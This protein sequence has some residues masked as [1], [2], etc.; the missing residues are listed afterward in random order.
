M[1]ISGVKKKIPFFIII[2]IFTFFGSK[3]YADRIGG[4]QVF[5]QPFVGADL[6]N[7]IVNVLRLKDP[8][9]SQNEGSFKFEKTSSVVVAERTV[10]IKGSETDTAPAPTE[11]YNLRRDYSQ[12]P[13]IISFGEKNISE[14]QFTAIKSAFGDKYKLTQDNFFAIN[15]PS[16]THY[17]IKITNPSAKGGY[18]KFLIGSAVKGDILIIPEKGVKELP[19]SHSGDVTDTDMSYETGF[20]NYL[21]KIIGV[22]PGSITA[23]IR[24]NDNSTIQRENIRQEKETVSK[25]LDSVEK[26]LN[27]LREKEAA[28]TLSSEE[29]QRIL[30]LESKKSD[31]LSREENLRRIELQQT[32]NSKSDT[33]SFAECKLF[34]P[35]ACVLPI[36]ATIANIGLKLVAWALGL[37]GVM[38]DYSIELA[39]NSAEFIERLGVVTP[40]WTL[41]RSFEHDLYFYT[42]L[43]SNT[44]NN[45]QKK[46]Y[47]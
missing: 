14:G 8:L 44:N 12:T 23:E 19:I 47:R 11:N 25:E 9:V 33:I 38:F 42:G 37:V 40:V 27:S 36:L 10:L 32:A 24:S 3:V 30:D 39:V 18:D 13:G 43:D 35:Q 41:L 26:E 1:N 34:S 5:R 4:A 7:T 29:R 16:G 15:T 17:Y 6:K 45:R 31:L 2:F 46:I 21:S 22:A 20:H 28:G